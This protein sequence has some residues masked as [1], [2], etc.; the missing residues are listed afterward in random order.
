MGD[1]VGGVAQH[2]LDVVVRE[3][4]VSVY[5]VGMVTENLLVQRPT[6]GIAVAR[7]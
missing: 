7:V 3:A 2:G 5:Q 4:R 6:T 1:R